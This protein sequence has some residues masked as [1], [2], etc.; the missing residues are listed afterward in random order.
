MEPVIS[1][2]FKAEPTMDK[3][4]SII[5]RRS[6]R[7]AS[8]LILIALWEMCVRFSGS[9]VAPSPWAS[10]KELWLLASKG[11][12][13][14]DW[15]ASMGRVLVGYLLA[16]LS[17]I[18]LGL[19][20]G[21]IP[22][23]EQALSP[24]IELFRPIPPIAWI[25]IS[26]ILL[27]LGNPS[28]Y[29]IIFLGAFYPIFTNTILGL[30]E[31]LPV[32]I[33][34]AK[35][36]GVP[37]WRRYL[38]VIWPSALPSIFAGLQVALGF[39]W[40]CVVAA[41][42]V[43]A[44]SGLGYEIQ[45]NRQALNID[46]VVAGMIVIGLTGLGMGRVMAFLTWL[47]LPWRRTVHRGKTR[48][49]KGPNFEDTKQ[50]SQRPDAQWL[51][52]GGSL[53]IRDLCFS[54]PGSEEI[55]SK[56][57]LTTSPGEV[58][59]LLGVSGSGKSTL[60]RLIAGLEVPNSGSISIN[61]KPACLSASDVT[62]V[63]QSGALFPWKTALANVEFGVSPGLIDQRR[64]IALKCLDL[65]QLKSKAD[66]YPHQLSGGQQQRVALARALA[67]R[68]RVLLLDEPFAALDSQTRELLQED[69]STLLSACGVTVII[70]THDIS[71]ALFLADRV[72]VIDHYGGRI[73]RE[74]RVPAER[75]RGMAFRDLAETQ[76]M[77]AQ[78]R[79][80]LRHLNKRTPN[81][82]SL[83]EVTL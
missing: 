50:P 1:E 63:F 23:M 64:A 17:G 24:T 61:G 72:L 73:A 69:L 76:S 25:P 75:P 21:I 60:L 18:G 83:Q 9:T 51:D 40:M 30:R 70:V 58:V 20:F 36:L 43:A 56:I 49:G 4:Y 57:S 38:H 80:T 67:N 6:L 59:G 42:M 65:V 16:V 77:V 47:F 53:E 44:D 78:L 3:N 34:A 79:S 7:I 15:S 68:P 5:R 35:S 54:Y 28:A 81:F 33:E 55:L 22:L 10:T 8:A 48:Q 74:L 32:Y 52:Q 62:M 37:L 26:V 29:F 2:C 71:E 46:A 31:V 66:N 82:E 39:A 19:L 14:S 11:P 12:L 27:G 41:E 45:L 13:L